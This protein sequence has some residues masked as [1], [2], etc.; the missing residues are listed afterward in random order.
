MGL[1]HT[2]RYGKPSLVLDLVEEF[3]VPIIDSTIFP[4]FSNKQMEKAENFEPIQPGVCRLSNDGKRKIVEAVYNRFKRA[5][6]LGRQKAGGESG[7]PPSDAMPGPAFSGQTQRLRAV[8][9]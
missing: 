5:G 2:E 8:S 4:L 7:H 3:R 9:I 1:Y 6:V